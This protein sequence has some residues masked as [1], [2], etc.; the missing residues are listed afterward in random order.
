MYYG[1]R[2]KQT[3]ERIGIKQKEIAYELNIK[4]NLYSEY[5]SEYQIIPLK[6]LITVANILNVSIDYIFGFTDKPQY[7]NIN[8]EIDKKNVGERL[9][10]FRKENN[11]TQALLAESIHTVHQVI[12]NYENG[13]FLIGLPFLNSLCKKYK[14]SADYLLGRIDKKITFEKEENK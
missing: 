8:K 3:R 13:K 14:I 4:Y 6:H 1:K 5:E 9:R 10:N 7:K 12:A 2:L 11:L